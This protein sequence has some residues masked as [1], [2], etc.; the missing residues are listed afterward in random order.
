MYLESM[1]GVVC[2]VLLDYFF[3]FKTFLCIETLL[4]W[5][6]CISKKIAWSLPF[7]KKQNIMKN[8]SKSMSSHYKVSLIHHSRTDS[9]VNTEIY[10]K[11]PEKVSL[12][13]PSLKWKLLANLVLFLITICNLKQLRMFS[14]DFI[15]LD[16]VCKDIEPRY[17]KTRTRGFYS[18]SRVVF[19]ITW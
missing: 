17:G 16:L 14:N 2:I 18:T 1:R 10:K 12:G 15:N 8:A 3:K 11:T 9:R 5:K 4:S 19:F 7:S 6:S 13:I